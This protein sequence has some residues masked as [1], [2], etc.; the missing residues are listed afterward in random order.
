MKKTI[1]ASVI[2]I[3]AAAATAAI[4]AVILPAHHRLDMEHARHHSSVVPAVFDPDVHQRPGAA[5]RAGDPAEPATGC[6]YLESSGAAVS[7]PAL[8]KAKA[9][10]SCPFLDGQREG[11]QRD[12][13]I[14][15][16]GKHT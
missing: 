16:V 7:C 15:L 10:T 9:G 4:L 8:P 6:P 3:L 14:P 1:E 5:G 12:L 2:L 13:S 11:V